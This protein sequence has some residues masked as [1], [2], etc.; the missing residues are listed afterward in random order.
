MPDI[1]SPAEDSY[2]LLKVLGKKVP[3]LLKENPELKVLEMGSGSGIHLEAL[4]KIGVKNLFAAD[5]N[6][7]AVEHCKKLGFKCVESNLFENI[8][9]KFDLIVFNPPYL[10]RDIK[11][12][13]SSQIATTGGKKGNEVINKFIEQSKNHLNENG[14]IFLLTSSH[15]AKINYNGYK[16]KLLDKESLFFEQLFVWELRT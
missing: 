13:K 10:P 2:L 15:T 11:E 5:I 7:D 1:Y 14:K 9:D 4:K 6:S 12:P 16:K 8:K 3:E